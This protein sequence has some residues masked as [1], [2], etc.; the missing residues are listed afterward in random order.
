MGLTQSQVNVLLGVKKWGRG[1]MSGWETY[2]S[3]AIILQVSFNNLFSLSKFVSNNETCR[4][5]S[6]EANDMDVCGDTFDSTG[7][8]DIPNAQYSAFCG[9]VA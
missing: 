4:S 7:E 3:R 2:Q 1:R 5:D 6:P 9:P 8:D